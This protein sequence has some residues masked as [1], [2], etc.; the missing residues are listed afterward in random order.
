MMNRLN[1][2]RLVDHDRL[3]RIP[4]AETPEGEDLVRAAVARWDD[5]RDKDIGLIVCRAKQLTETED[6]VNRTEMAE[7]YRQAT[8]AVLEAGQDLT[9]TEAYRKVKDMVGGPLMQ[10][11]WEVTYYYPIKKELRKNGKPEGRK[12]R[13]PNPAFAPK[14]EVSGP[15]DSAEEADALVDSVMKDLEEQFAT[16]ETPEEDAENIPEIIPTFRWNSEANESISVNRGPFWLRASKVDG[17]WVLT[18]HLEL[19]EQE[20]LAKII[21]SDP[22]FARILEF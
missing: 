9:R 3:A 19:L 1:L 8:R 7:K 5:L 2:T 18:I 22:V 6:D 10:S 13:R 12:K 21:G 14:A 11:S 15:I 16:A 4:L 20:E 17:L